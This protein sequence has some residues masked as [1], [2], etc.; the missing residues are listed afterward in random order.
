MS[1]SAALK[2]YDRRRSGNCYRV[3]LM[4]GFLGLPY[5]RIPI[6]IGG[7]ASVFSGTHD[8][9]EK[10]HPSQGHDDPSKRGENTQEWFLAKNPRGQIPVLEVEGTCIPDSIAIIVYLAR[11]FGGESWLPTDPGA[12]AEIARWLVVSQTDLLYGLARAR[13]VR[14]LNRKGDL[15]EYQALGHAG[16]RVMEARLS[17][18]QRLACDRA[19]IADVACY[20][21]PAQADTSGVD[22]TAYPA[23]VRWLK[24]VEALPGYPGPLD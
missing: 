5:E 2:L 11:R 23:I 3:R 4:L 17:E 1:S 16:L 18:H 10:D 12:M 22:I 9:P 8:M 24:R 20:P 15:A 7:A 14:Q 21:Y 19:T 6:N 13:G